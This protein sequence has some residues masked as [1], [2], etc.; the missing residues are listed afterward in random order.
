MISFLNFI[1]DNWLP[2]ALISSSIWG[3][4]SLQFTAPPGSSYSKWYN[5]LAGGFHMFM[6]NFVCSLAGWICFYVLSQKYLSNTLK[7]ELSDFILLIVVILGLSGDIPNI[8]FNIQDTFRKT[9]DI[10]ANL[11]RSKK[12]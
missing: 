4:S 5:Q 12:Q 7:Y 6:R 8:F 2:F 1:N 10:L 3:I 11:F 9:G